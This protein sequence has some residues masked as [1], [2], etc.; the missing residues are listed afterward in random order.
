MSRKLVILFSLII[1]LIN[2]SCE[3][4]EV[5]YQFHEL[6]SHNW[7]K[8]DT[9]SFDIDSASIR[10]NVPLIIQLDLVNNSDYPYQNIWLYIYDNF[11][12]SI[13]IKNEKQYEVADKTGKWLGSG[14]GSLYQLTVDYKTIIFTEKRNYQVK[15]V[16][17]M[18]DEPL[19]GIE[20]IGLKLCLSDKR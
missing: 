2:T 5:Y 18:R 16:Q 19:N 10:L 11:S 9:I 8:N 4:K 6:K 13:L 12:D 3:H 1:S 15:V 17:G 14:F 7:S 20:K